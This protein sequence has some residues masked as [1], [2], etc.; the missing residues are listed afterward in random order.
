MMMDIS[1][2]FPVENG[3]KLILI[4]LQEKEINKESY[5]L[6]TDWSL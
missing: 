3:M 5:G 4:T 1:L 2:P 6:T